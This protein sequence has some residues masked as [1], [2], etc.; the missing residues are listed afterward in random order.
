MTGRRREG[1]AWIETLQSRW[2]GANNLKHHL[3]WHQALYHLELGEISSYPPGYKEN[4]G[5][6][7]HNNTWIHLGW[8]LLGDG[9]RAVLLLEHDERAFGLAVAEVTGVVT[10]TGRVG[11]PRP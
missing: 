4:A 6:F 5:I 8:C 11:P 1:I 9:D 2:A 3:W 10:P 7:C